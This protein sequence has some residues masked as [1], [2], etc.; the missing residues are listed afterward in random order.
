MFEKATLNSKHKHSELVRQ[1]VG[2]KLDKYSFNTEVD[3]IIQKGYANNISEALLV[4]DIYVTLAQ[5]EA[6]E[7]ENIN[8]AIQ[9]QINEK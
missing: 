9:E 3:F 1:I 5:C 7:R 6:L 8:R 4:N 2:N